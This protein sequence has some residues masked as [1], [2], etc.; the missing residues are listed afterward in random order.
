MAPG[1]T[2]NPIFDYFICCSRFD[3]SFNFASLFDRLVAN[4]AHCLLHKCD[5]CHCRP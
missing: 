1:T 4:T 2:V 3:W 5:W